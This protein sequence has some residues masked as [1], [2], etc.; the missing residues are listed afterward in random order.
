MACRAYLEKDFTLNY[1]RTKTQLE[2]DF[3]LNQGQV[4]IETT[5]SE[6]IRAGDIKGLI[7]MMEESSAEKYIVVCQEKRQRLIN[8]TAGKNIMVLPWQ[9]FLKQLWRGEI[10]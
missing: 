9:T 1:W 7:A 4:C 10:I 5:V 3:V 6:R 2:V 8:I